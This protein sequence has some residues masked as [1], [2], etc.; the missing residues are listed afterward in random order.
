MGRKKSTVKWMLDTC[1]T[2]PPHG[3]SERIKVGERW[4]PRSTSDD[5]P[6]LVGRAVAFVKTEADPKLLKSDAL[7]DKKKVL[8]QVL[9]T[10][11]GDHPRSSTMHRAAEKYV[12]DWAAEQGITLKV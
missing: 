9:H 12:L 8:Y 7:P 11:W 3:S 5:V 10:V 2:F 1:A 4:Y 6:V